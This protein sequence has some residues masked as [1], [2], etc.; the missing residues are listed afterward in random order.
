[1]LPLLTSA[2]LTLLTPLDT[3][4]A[5][6]SP[7]VSRRA[8]LGRLVVPAAAL[9]PLSA[10]AEEIVV[11][12]CGE[13]ADD[14][15]FEKRRKAL[16]AKTKAK[17]AA[18]AKKRIEDAKKGPLRKPSDLVETRKKTVDYSCVAATG[19]PCPTDEEN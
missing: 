15:C 10:T 1:M 8:A 17:A 13:D 19:S 14:A 16:V 5:P 6:A 4:Q 2:A 12:E 9:W 3:R 11:P 7:T 18:A